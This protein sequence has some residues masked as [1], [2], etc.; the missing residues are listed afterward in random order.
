MKVELSKE[1]LEVLERALN[2]LAASY[3][4]KINTTRDNEERALYERKLASL[5]QTTAAIRTR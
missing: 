5:D 1:N 2:T 4:R 3:N